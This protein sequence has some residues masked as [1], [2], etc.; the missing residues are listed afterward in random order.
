MV[1]TQG[2]SVNALKRTWTDPDVSQPR[3]GGRPEPEPG[4]RGAAGAL[5]LVLASC[6][7]DPAAIATSRDELAFAATAVQPTAVTAAAQVPLPAG[8]IT[9]ITGD[10][11]TVRT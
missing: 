10:R 11:V 7:E 8:A 2:E 3:C 9:L 5:A 6:G 1:S 4:R